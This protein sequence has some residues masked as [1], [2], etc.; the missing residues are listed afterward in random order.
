MKNKGGFTFIE[1]LIV[2]GV[3]A[4]LATAVVVTVNPTRRFED[5][6]DKQREIHLQTILS[7]I[8]RK[9]TIEAGWSGCAPLPQGD[10]GIDEETGLIKPIFKTIGTLR[11]PENPEELDPNYYNLF[12]CLVPKYMVNELYDPGGG[13]A[14]DTNYQIWQNPQTKYVTLRYVK[15]EPYKEIVAGAKKYVILRPPTVTTA[16]TTKITHTSAEGGGDVT[17]DGGA[18]VLERGVIWGTNIGLTIL[19]DRIVVSSGIGTF[20]GEIIGLTHDTPYYARAYAKNDI[21]VGYGD[22]VSFRTLDARPGVNTLEAIN[23]SLDRATLQGEVTSLGPPG[24]ASVYRYFKWGKTVECTG[25]CPNKVDADVKLGG[26]GEFGHILYDLETNVEYSFQACAANTYPGERCGETKFFY[27]EPSPP[28]VTT[29]PASNIGAYGATIGG[30]IEHTGG[31]TVTSWG[32]CYAEGIIPSYPSDD[33][34]IEEGSVI[35]YPFPFNRNITDLKPGREY[36]FFAFAK[37]GKGLRQGENLNF[38]TKIQPPTVETMIENIG[39]YIADLGGTI[40]GDGGATIQEYGVCQDIWPNEPTYPF[41]CLTK[42]GGQEGNTFFFTFKNFLIG[43][44]YNVKAFAKNNKGVSQNLPETFSP[45]GSAQ[46]PELG[47]TEVGEVGVVTAEFKGIIKN[48]GGARITDHGFCWSNEGIPDDNPDS[49]PADA[50]CVGKGIFDIGVVEDT[51]DSDFTFST[52]DLT[53][54]TLYYVVAFAQNIQGYGYGFPVPITT[55]LCDPPEVKTSYPPDIGSNYA[56]AGGNITKDGGDPRTKGG[57]CY[58]LSYLSQ[59]PE[60]PSRPGIDVCTDD[61][62]GVG[63][64]TSEMTDLVG[65]NTYY[66]RAYADNPAGTAYGTKYNFVAGLAD[67]QSCTKNEDCRNTH[68]FDEVCCNDTCGGKCMACNVAGHVG[69]CTPIPAGQDPDNDCATEWTGCKS[70]CVRQGSS[71]YCNGAGS[72]SLSALT[73]P[74]PSGSVCAGRGE[75]TPVSSS[76]YCN[77]HNVCIDGACTGTKYFISCNG[78]GSCRNSTDHTDSAFE[79]VYAAVGRTLTSSCGTEGTTLCGYSDP[80]GC[81]GACRQKRDQLR[82]NADHTCAYDVGDDFANC[83]ANTYCSGNSCVPGACGGLCSFCSQT[84]SCTDHQC[85]E[86]DIINNTCIPKVPGEYGLAVCKRCNGISLD[87]VNVADNTQDAEGSNMCNVPCVKC[88]SGQCVNQT[89]AQDLFNQCSESQCYTGNCNGFGACGYQTAS[90]DLWNYCAQGTT[91]SDGCKAEYCSGIDAGCS[92]QTS[93]EGGCPVCGKCTG[94]TSIACVYHTSGTVDNGCSTCKACNGNEI[95]N[96]TGASPN[97]SW[98]ANNYGCTGTSS[99]CYNGSC[100]T[101]GGWLYSDGCSGCAGQGGMG[102]WR[103]GAGGAS[104][105]TACS[106]FGGCVAANWNDTTSCNVC[107][108]WYPSGGCN[109]NAGGGYP[110]RELWYGNCIYRSGGQDCAATVVL[111]APESRLCVCQY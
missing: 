86:P 12:D 22:E 16:S 30:T 111:W 20:E 107:Y 5:A 100:R 80:N 109:G 50:D 15:E 108:H 19:D 40:T 70:S 11:N 6:R 53:P 64:F 78:L 59:D 73:E 74:I 43:Q 35:E 13:S 2:I 1:T 88:S 29:K 72:C 92:F 37:N 101:C 110:V 104:C 56:L 76:N 45:E 65:G 41:D 69:T 39:N 95:N 21:G 52:E 25:E 34:I 81:S 75:I 91:A 67:G 10:E 90:Q 62:I 27:T 23:V 99:R 46:I 24:I 51:I 58:S 31:E 103:V 38:T 18:P 82:C 48:N 87:P 106:S 66:Y 28:V 54:G 57:V 3:I 96:C 68:C 97:T 63:P 49:L 55:E 83:S 4:I 9:M 42:S 79:P 89:S 33:C 32:V 47:Q 77:I 7:A 8:E 36:W 61:G 93:G 17:S 14:T 85:G 71:G 94:A 44:Q 26:L 60:Y 102:C 84:G 105:N 98:G